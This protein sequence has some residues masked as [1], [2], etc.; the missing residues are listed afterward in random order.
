MPGAN[1]K[2]SWKRGGS[3]LLIVTLEREMSLRIG[4]L[5]THRLAGGT[6]AYVGSAKRGIGARVERH[7]RLARLKRG[8]LR[9]HID[10]LLAAPHAAL[11]DAFP[12]P[13]VDEC[14]LSRSLASVRGV[15]APVPG[16]GASDCTG[17]C[18]AHFYRLP[19]LRV[20]IANLAGR[21]GERL[22]RNRT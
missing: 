22:R 15:N 16:F 9:W 13:G 3:Y 11:L 20:P 8:P 18:R 5:G 2:A 4:A 1:G 10:F 21:I 7:R 12:F 14:A 6:Y 17:G 19:P